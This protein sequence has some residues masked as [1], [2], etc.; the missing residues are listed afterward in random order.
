[1]HLW[2][3]WFRSF[4]LPVHHQVAFHAVSVVKVGL[5]LLPALTEDKLVK[6]YTWNIFRGS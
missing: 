4:L 6:M 1:M 3:I 2:I 5:K